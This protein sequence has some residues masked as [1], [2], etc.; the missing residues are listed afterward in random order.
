MTDTLFPIPKELF[1]TLRKANSEATVRQLVIQ[2]LDCDEIK[3]EEGGTDA[4]HENILI[5]FKFDEDMQHKEGKRAHILAQA[6]YYCHNFYIDGKRVPHYVALVD[7]DEFVFYERETLESIY[8]DLSLFRH[9]NA[10]QPDAAVIE[11]CKL[12]D[13]YRYIFVH[14]QDDLSSAINLLRQIVHSKIVSK[15][16][17][18]EYTVIELYSSWSDLFTRFLN[19]K[20]QENKPHVFRKDCSDEGEVI[21]IESDLIGSEVITIQFNLDNEIA[22]IE[23]CPKSEYSDF[24]SQWNRITDRKREKIIF[25]TTADLF[26]MEVRRR[27]GQFYTPTNLAKHG[28]AYLEKELGENFWFDGTWRIWDCCCGEGGLAINVI[29]P[30]A[31]QYTYLSSLDAGEV[32]FVKR[33]MPMCKKVW[34][35]DFLNTQLQDFPEEVKRDMEN[36]QIKWLFFINPP[37]GEGSSGKATDD[38]E[39]YKKGVSLSLVKEQMKN[40]NMSVASKEKY[41]QFLFRIEK[42]FK[43]RYVMGSYTTMKAFVSKEYAN[44]RKFWRPV[45]KGGLICCANKWHQGNGAFPSVFSVFDCRVKGKWGAMEY[46]ILEY[47]KGYNKGVFRGKKSFIQEDPKRSFRDHFFPKEGLPNDELTVVQANGLKSYGGKS[48]MSNNRPKGT[49][50]SAGFISAYMRQQNFSRMVSGNVI[51]NYV[52]IFINKGN[53]KKVLCGLGLYWSIKPSWY[54]NADF[55]SAPSRIL[56]A[57]EET[58]AALYTLVCPRN[59]T[60]TVRLNETIITTNKGRTINGGIIVENKLNPFDKKLFDWSECSAV[61]KEVLRLY[62]HYLNNIVKWKEQETVLGKGEW[63]GL[64]QY[65]RIVP[66]PKELVNAIEKLRQSVEQTALEVCF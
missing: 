25:Q 9:G 24:W 61:G 44:L 55:L 11:K 21:K 59:R 17:I 57:Q 27:K 32:D 20:G 16:D 53:Y 46:N 64:Y 19:Q 62:K 58:D 29:P 37:Y 43:G 65:H 42:E 13:P 60:T 14:N 41:A 22:K 31:Q 1:R 50:A 26:N 52:P 8:T 45:F 12:V 18:T 6:L 23:R 4:L 49:W 40:H 36:D 38:T 3:L 34:Q 2:H 48:K 66:K 15:R 63:L 56:T 7:K 39:W 47:K 51:D 10:S 54:N 28:W 33:H 5:E 30:S 35:M